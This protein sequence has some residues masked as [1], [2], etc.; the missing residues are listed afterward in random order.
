M[1]T[2]D[3]DNVVSDHANV[4]VS[5]HESDGIGNVS[6]CFKCSC[7]QINNHPNDD[8]ACYRL[9]TQQRHARQNAKVGVVAPTHDNNYKNNHNWSTMRVVRR[10][11]TID[12]HTESDDNASDDSIYDRNSTEN[13]DCSNHNIKTNMQNNSI[14]NKLR[15]IVRQSGL[16]LG[17]SAHITHTTNIFKYQRKQPSWTVYA[18]MLIVCTGFAVARPNAGGVD[19]TVDATTSKSATDVSN[20]TIYTLF[21]FVCYFYQYFTRT[22]YT[23]T[24]ALKSCTQ[25][26]YLLQQMTSWCIWNKMQLHCIS[27]RNYKCPLYNNSH[28]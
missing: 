27:P 2:H 21:L 7:K 10:M 1:A 8:K 13:I 26:L 18:L 3:C 15:T 14:F 5:L 22:H 11:E 16:L 6:C 28:R 19:N 9:L 25:R 12:R 23:R 17:G 24:N 20:Y 4:S